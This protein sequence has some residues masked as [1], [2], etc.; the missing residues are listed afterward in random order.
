MILK[1]G[2]KTT[3]V[4]FYGV[5][6]G[7]DASTFFTAIPLEVKAAIPL[8]TEDISDKTSIITQQICHIL[9]KERSD[10]QG[11]Q[12]YLKL[13][14]QMNIEPSDFG[15]IY[16]SLYTIISTIMKKKV[17]LNTACDDLKKMNVPLRIIDH[18]RSNLTPAIRMDAESAIKHNKTF[19]PRLSH[20]K[21]RVDVIISS[22]ELAKVLR[23]RILMQVKFH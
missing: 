22:N 21:W 3:E 10:E 12:A 8:M 17:M 9:T 16:T 23:P 18:I 6:V 5:P 1:F 19:V 20:L 4:D 11:D 2:T 15:L 13:L 14:E 7:I